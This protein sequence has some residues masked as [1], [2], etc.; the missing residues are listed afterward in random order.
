MALGHYMPL[1]GCSENPLCSHVEV[2]TLLVQNKCYEDVMEQC[3]LSFAES[4]SLQNHWLAGCC[5]ETV[6]CIP[7]H[8]VMN[9]L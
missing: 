4:A 9:V 7:I 5:D 2:V 3:K 6:S 1:T 8:T